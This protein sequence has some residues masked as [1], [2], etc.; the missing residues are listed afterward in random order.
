MKTIY[1]KRQHLIIQTKITSPNNDPMTTPAICPLNS[2]VFLATPQG[3]YSTIQKVTLQDLLDLRCKTITS[4]SRALITI[5]SR[6]YVV[7]K[8]LVFNK[9]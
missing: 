8:A 1:E 7:V 2:K 5:L 3:N 9:E 4:T 6:L